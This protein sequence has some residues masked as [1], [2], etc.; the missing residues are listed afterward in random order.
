MTGISSN[1][2]VVGRSS[3]FVI[4]DQPAILLL[5]KALTLPAL[6]STCTTLDTFDLDAQ[7]LL[8]NQLTQSGT[9]SSTVQ[10]RLSCVPKN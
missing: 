4:I 7:N 2:T 9:W 3:S 6:K 8:L 5:Q 1:A 10:W